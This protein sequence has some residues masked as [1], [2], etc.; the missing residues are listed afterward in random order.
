MCLGRWQDRHNLFPCLNLVEIRKDFIFEVGICLVVFLLVEIAVFG[1]VYFHQVFVDIVAIPGNLGNPA[2]RL[3]QHLSLSH[4]GI[5]TKASTENGELRVGSILG[6][7]IPAETR[8]GLEVEHAVVFVFLVFDIVKRRVVDFYDSLSG[9]GSCRASVPV[10]THIAGTVAA[11][12][13]VIVLQEASREGFAAGESE[14]F[15][16]VLVGPD[17]FDSCF[18]LGIGQVVQRI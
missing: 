4:L 17:S 15:L 11:A 18:R 13:D 7:E 5:G 8:Q 10:K 3:C 16:G 2:S 14:E 9:V 12:I 6:A 1:S